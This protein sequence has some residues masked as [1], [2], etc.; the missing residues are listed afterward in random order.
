MEAQKSILVPNAGCPENTEENT[1]RCV[2]S[3]TWCE[4]ENTLA[5][6]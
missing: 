5:Y 2:G 4:K 3:Y 1:L 6:E